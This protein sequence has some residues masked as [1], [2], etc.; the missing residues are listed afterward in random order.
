MIDKVGFVWLC[1]PIVSSLKYVKIC[2]TYL[3]API[4]PTVNT[5]LHFVSSFVGILVERQDE[6]GWNFIY[7][8]LSGQLLLSTIGICI[9]RAV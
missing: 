5:A 4:L 2:W 6:L 9:R 7:E 3:T 1:H 8:P